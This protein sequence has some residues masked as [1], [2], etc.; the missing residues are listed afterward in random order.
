[1]GPIWA[2]SSDRSWIP[3]QIYP[4]GL[5]QGALWPPVPLGPQAISYF[6][7][8]PQST[9]H[10]MRVHA[11][12]AHHAPSRPL[13]QAWLTAPN[14]PQVHNRSLRVRSGSQPIIQHVM[15]CG[16]RAGQWQGPRQ[17]WAAGCRFSNTTELQEYL[18][19]LAAAPGP[20]SIR[21]LEQ[22]IAF[23]HPEPDPRPPTGIIRREGTSEAAPEVV[24]QAVEGGC[25]S[26][27][28]RLLSVTN[29]IQAGTCVQ[30]DS[31]WA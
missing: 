30:G 14:C 4:A 19:R 26:G 20:T 15:G 6:V 18:R 10:N 23:L 29:A 31:G 9:K 3:L 22:A 5:A 13:L 7:D 28:W 25:R 1:M 2:S 17:W 27:S 12:L 21:V 11:G 24:K 16:S 8:P